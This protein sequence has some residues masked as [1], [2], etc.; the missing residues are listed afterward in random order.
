VTAVQAAKLLPLWQVYSGLL[1]SDTA[2]QTEIDALIEQIQDTMTAEQIKAINAMDLTQQDVLAVMQEQGAGISQH[3]TTA[4]SDSSNSSAQDDGMAPPDGGGGMPMG[5]S[6]DDGGGMPM[7]DTGGTD[8][9]E[10]DTTGSPAMNP[11][12]LLIDALIELLQGKIAS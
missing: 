4:S 1:T 10:S 3:S 2:A 9:T 5:S 8:T 11:L 12:S 6:P 7:G